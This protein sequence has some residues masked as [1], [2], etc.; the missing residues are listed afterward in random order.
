MGRTGCGFGL[1]GQNWVH[2]WVEWSEQDTQFGRVG[3][4]S[5]HCVE[6][7]EQDALEA[8]IMNLLLL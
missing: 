5:A 2:S 3:R 4:T 6:W 8:A 1:S 7:A